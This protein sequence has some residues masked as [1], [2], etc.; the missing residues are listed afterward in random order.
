M[1]SN[2]S[3]HQGA[4]VS[5]SD[6]MPVDRVSWEDCQTF[7]K[8]LNER[9]A[10]RGFRLPTEAEWEYAARAG[11]G[12]TENIDLPAPNPVGQGLPNQLGLFDLLGNVWEWCSSI[13]ARWCL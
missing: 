1:G 2:P 10:S 4:D 11:S 8:K 6:R 5:N 13:C 7:L 9:V 3:A 12:A